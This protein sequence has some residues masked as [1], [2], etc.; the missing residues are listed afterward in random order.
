LIAGSTSELAVD[1]ALDR[2]NKSIGR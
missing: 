1:F 2:D